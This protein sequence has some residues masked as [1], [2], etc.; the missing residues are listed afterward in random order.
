[1]EDRGKVVPLQ[2]ADRKLRLGANPEY[3]KITLKSKSRATI[4]ARAAE[5]FFADYFKASWE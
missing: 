2:L 1:M 5:L 3:H 4:Q